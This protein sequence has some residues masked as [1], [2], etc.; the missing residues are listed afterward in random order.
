MIQ[1]NLFEHKEYEIEVLS[2]VHIGNGESLQ[3]YEYIFVNDMNNCSVFFLNQ[4]KWLHYLRGHGLLN[5]Y[6][7]QV[8][9][10][11]R[12][13]FPW[14]QRH[15]NPD[16]LLAVMEE[17]AQSVAPVYI[18]SSSKKSLNYIAEQV[19]SPQGVPYIPGSSLKGAIRRG[20]LYHLI[21]Q[22]P[23]KFQHITNEIRMNGNWFK[24]NAKEYAKELQKK[25]LVDPKKKSDR[26]NDMLRDIMRGIRISDAMPVDKDPDTVVVQKYDASSKKVNPKDKDRKEPH[27]LALFRECIPAGR[28]FRFSITMKK[29]MVSYGKIHS[30][31]EILEW[32]R[33]FFTS[34]LKMQEKVFGD[35][36]YKAFRESATCDFLLGGGTGFLSKTVYYAIAP[37]E[38]AQYILKKYFDIAF[39][40]YNRDT[41]RKEPMHHHQRDDKK[42]TP[43][44]LKL[45]KDEMDFSLMGMVSLKEVE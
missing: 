14:L 37:E 43:R 28:K 33:D 7:A 2:P 41:K 22:N 35:K 45:V 40:R 20:I 18:D 34:G 10:H 13:I 32:T 17:V 5:D 25:A 9:Q 27:T 1:K 11:K 16:D 39:A 26:Q 8:I 19:K 6:V 31:D 44:T 30:I 36:Y 15:V 4:A 21:T 23:K 12:P 29:E 24:K 3:P 42:I 38:S